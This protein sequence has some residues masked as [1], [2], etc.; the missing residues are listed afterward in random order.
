MYG[1]RLACARSLAKSDSELRDN[2]LE[3]LGFQNIEPEPDGV[4]RVD[5]ADLEVR[6]VHS[7]VDM[8]I[9]VELVKSNSV[10]SHMCWHVPT[11]T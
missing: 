10:L 9:R 4:K 1:Q 5:P 8:V 6:D 11:V 2:E 7:V 3:P